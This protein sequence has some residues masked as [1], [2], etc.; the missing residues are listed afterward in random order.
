MKQPNVVIIAMNKPLDN[1][2]QLRQKMI[3]AENRAERQSSRFPGLDLTAIQKG[4]HRNILDL[5]LGVNGRHMDL[6]DL[7]NFVKNHGR[8]PDLT[9]DNVADYYSLAHMVTLNGIYL[10]HYLGNQGYDPILIQ[11]FATADLADTLQERPLAV[12]ISSNF[13]LMDEIKEI[14]GHIKQCA[15][16][17][18][19][20]AGGMLIKKVLD[21]GK[22]L[23]P[24]ALEYLSTFY[25]KVD[26]FIVEAQGEQT[27]AGLLNSLRNGGELDKIPNLAFFNAQGKV[28]FTARIKEDLPIDL[29]AIAWGKIPGRYL[30]HTLPVNSSRGCFYRCRF[31]TYHWLFPEVHYKSLEV[32]RA[33]LREIRRLGFV[34]HIRFTDDNFTANK[35]RLKAVLQIMI[36]EEFD[37]TWSSFAR[38]SALTPELVKL[39]K[40]SGCEF[41]DMGIES[42][43]QSIL[44]DMDKKLKREQ[45]ITAIQMLNEHGIYSR[46]SFI[47]GY[48]GETRQTFSETIELINESGLPYY[49]PYLFYYSRN[50]KIYEERARFHLKG[51]G[52]AWRHDTMDAVEASYLMSQ[53]V[54]MI[55]GAYTDGLSYLEE[56]FKLL[57]GEGYSTEEIETLFRLKRELQLATKDPGSDQKP[58][59]RTDA[60]FAQLESLV[61]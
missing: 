56:I 35:A 2:A 30:S 4:V 24:Q 5:L 25:G 48:P 23:S 19:V 16:E 27:L 22:N 38:A 18:P 9:P 10:Y 60:I 7:M 49:H 11:N 39:M 57:R 50:S 46:G 21:Q 37:F 34:K 54:R 31:C 40:A 15:P 53:M 33:E 29:T 3:S 26:V 17:V 61:R 6:L 28:E 47:I 52:L 14:A 41:V 32:L 8:A 45:S 44:D 1:D 36:E 13:I 12:C 20:I 59:K 58:A 55:K 43:S 42:G 51:L